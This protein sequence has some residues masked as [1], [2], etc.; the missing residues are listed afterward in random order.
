MLCR[1]VPCISENELLSDDLS[2]ICTPES[3]VQIYNPRGYT[4]TAEVMA[5]PCLNR[6]ALGKDFFAS[7]TYQVIKSRT[8]YGI[9]TLEMLGSHALHMSRRA[10]SEADEQSVP[11]ASSSGDHGTKPA[12]MEGTRQKGKSRRFSLIAPAFARAIPDDVQLKAIAQV[13]EDRRR[14]SVAIRRQSLIQSLHD[15]A[16]S[17]SSPKT[18]GSGP[19]GS[20]SALMPEPSS[21]DTIGALPPRRYS[22]AE[23]GKLGWTASDA[24]CPHCWCVDHICP[25]CPC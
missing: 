12:T 9:V 8:K 7:L 6:Q 19:R 17:Y 20:I 18:Y 2:S 24:Y 21:D 1:Q 10:T 22:I 3:G 16:G 23:Q 13:T 5:C 4:E 14:A 25:C 15:D 11:L